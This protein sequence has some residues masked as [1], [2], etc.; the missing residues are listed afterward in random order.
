MLIYEYGN[1]AYVSPPI[2]TLVKQQVMDY[3][4][5]VPK[6]SDQLEK[7]KYKWKN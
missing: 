4:L 3:C 5:K 7:V 1:M 2:Y 6:H